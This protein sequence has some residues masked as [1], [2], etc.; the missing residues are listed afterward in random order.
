MN[1]TRLDI[2]YSVGKLSRYIGNLGHEH[3][4]ALLRVLDYLKRTKD[5]VL[6]YDKYPALLEGYCDANWILDSN[7][8]KSTSG[9]VFILGG[10]A[11][12]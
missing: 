7:E 9:Y 12:S 6:Q 11:V 4:D 8:S 10:A 2:A 5:Y 3:W 1:Y